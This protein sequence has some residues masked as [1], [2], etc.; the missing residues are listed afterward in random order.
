MLRYLQSS[1]S[2]SLAPPIIPPGGLRMPP[3]RPQKRMATVF[4][5]IKILI[6]FWTRFLVDFGSS[7]GAKLGSF[8]ALLAPKFGQVASKTR[9]GSLS[10]SKNVNFHQTLRLPMFQR[11]LEP[12]DGLQ[13]A[14]RSA[15]DG[16]K[17]LLKSN[18]FALENRLKF[19]LVLG[20]ILA[21]FWLPNPSR[22]TWATP[23]SFAF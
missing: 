1:K 16:S 21:R 17:R 7:W 6:I 5:S 23:P 2:E 4:C 12:Q 10:T 20:A 11:F 22:K 13:N 18:F 8:S 9:L 3:G 15:Q 14:P 19:G